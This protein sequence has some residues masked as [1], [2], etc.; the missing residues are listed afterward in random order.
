MERTI[1]IAEIDEVPGEHEFDLSVEIIEPC[2]TEE[3][4]PRLKIILTNTGC[5]SQ[6]LQT[7]IRMPFSG[8]ESNEQ[9]P[10]LQ[11]LPSSSQE[12]DRLSDCWQ[13]D[14]PQGSEYA[15]RGVVAGTELEPKEE[16]AGI[17]EIWSHYANEECMP[18]GKYRFVGSYHGPQHSQPKFNWGFVI[19]VEQGAKV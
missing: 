8:F 14:L 4:P 19:R 6:R 15:Y 17:Y 16:I 1:S 10:G 11:L 13:L 5:S 3:H 9:N 18:P 7:A 2:A 12:R